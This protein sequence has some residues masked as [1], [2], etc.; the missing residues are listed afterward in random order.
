MAR[1]PDARG[2]VGRRSTTERPPPP[3]PRLSPR[4]PPPNDGIN[5]PWL[6]VGGVILSVVSCATFVSHVQSQADRSRAIVERVILAPS[7]AVPVELVDGG[8]EFKLS[9]PAPPVTIRVQYAGAVAGK[10]QIG[11]YLTNLFSAEAY[12][13]PNVVPMSQGEVTCS[14]SSPPYGNYRVSVDVNGERRGPYR[15]SVF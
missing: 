11:I 14:I 4:P 12:C 6:A 15:F 5:W 9:A 13:K 7:G 3:P 1:I 2:Y 8:D 10:D